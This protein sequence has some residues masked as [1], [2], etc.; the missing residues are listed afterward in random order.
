MTDAVEK[1]PNCLATNFPPKDESREGS[2]RLQLRE[3]V[4]SDAKRLFRQHRPVSELKSPHGWTDNLG[5]SFATD[6]RNPSNPD[7]ITVIQNSKNGSCV[8]E[9]R[10]SNASLAVR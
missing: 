7:R 3:F 5:L 10:A 9:Y 8:P 6:D 1:V 2:P 4:F